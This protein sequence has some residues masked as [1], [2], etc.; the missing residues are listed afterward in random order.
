LRDLGMGTVCRTPFL[1][2][3]MARTLSGTKTGWLWGAL[4]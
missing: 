4:D 2:S 3:Q 1:K